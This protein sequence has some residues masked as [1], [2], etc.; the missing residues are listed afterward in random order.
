[1]ARNPSGTYTLPAGNPVVEGTTI[2]PTWAN[3][4]L[5]D[6]ATALT[7]SLSRSG[8]GGMLGPLKIVDGAQGGPGLVFGLDTD[9]G[10]YR[11]AENELGIAV[12]GELKLK[13][14][15]GGISTNEGNV[16][17]FDGYWA[18]NGLP[19]TPSYAFKSE[20]T[21]GIYKDSAGVLGLSVLG[22]KR[23]ALSSTGLVITG[24]IEATQNL[25]GASIEATGAAGK[26]GV[27]ATGGAGFAGAVL[28]NG[29]AATAV[30]RQTACKLSNG[31]L[32]LDGVANPNPNVGLKNRITP[33]SIAKAWAF[34]QT[35]GLGGVALLGG[36]NIASVAIGGTQAYV[37]LTLAEPLSEQN[38]V[39]IIVQQ[40]SFGSP[41]PIDNYGAVVSP[42]GPPFA[43]VRVY[44]SFITYTPPPAVVNAINF[45]TA[46]K[47]FYVV[48]FGR[49]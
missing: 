24:N 36:M 43:G 12:A 19:A 47:I 23:A 44:G 39:A 30:T 22:T 45:A 2:T 20:Q 11:I 17:S 14:T 38:A 8:Q 5:S 13:I 15:G 10:M 9:T 25:K 46:S 42:V 34:V 16:D 4:T 33:A 35:D 49:Q 28:A 37:E 6:I 27:Q 41:N 31:D 3:Q 1:M 29:T 32:D 26:P 40:Y 21:T 7:E 48:V 18:P